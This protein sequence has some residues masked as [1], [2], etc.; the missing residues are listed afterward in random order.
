[1]IRIKINDKDGGDT[2]III[3]YTV[4]YSLLLF[5]TIVRDWFFENIRILQNSN[6]VIFDLATVKSEERYSLR[7]VYLFECL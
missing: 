3:E 2:V 5:L 1:M 7:T 4:Y 6:L